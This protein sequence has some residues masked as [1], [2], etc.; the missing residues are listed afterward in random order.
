[1]EENIAAA[2]IRPLPACSIYSLTLKIEEVHFSETL[3]K[4]CPTAQHHIPEESTPHSHY[5]ENFT[6]TEEL[7]RIN[8]RM[9][10]R[11]HITHNKKNKN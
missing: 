9:F 11:G 5:C 7:Q 4:F 8:E 2:K 1:L 6:S 3:V 10:I